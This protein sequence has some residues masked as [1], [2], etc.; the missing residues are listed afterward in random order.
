MKDE[1]TAPLVSVI[2]P[3][4]Q[5]APFIRTCL[6]SIL[7]Q[8]IAFPIEVLIG[9]D[10]STDGTR[11]ICQEIANAHPDR[12]RLFLNDRDNLIYLDGHPTGRR[13]VLDLYGRCRGRYI[14]LCEGD[15]LWSDPEKLAVQVEILERDRSCS[16]VFHATAVI[17]Q[18]GHPTGK[19]FRDHVPEKLTIHEAIAQRAPFHTSSLVFRNLPFLRK[20]PSWAE[21]VGSFDLVVFTLCAANGPLIGLQRN[22]SAYRKHEG[23]IT[24]SALHQGA[25]FD[26]HRI[27][28]WLHLDD[29]FHGR[30]AKEMGAAMEEH[31]RR[32]IGLCGRSERLRYLW[33]MTRQAPL[34]VLSH[35][36]RFA[37][38]WALALRA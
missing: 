21:K 13:N 10:G 15:D 38:W 20:P 32:L 35:P 27:L 3:T 18:D 37:R 24:R 16:G 31:F 28:V 34:Y 23:G 4:Y 5:H 12:I 26:H 17:D 14:A 33:Q 19:D 6:M 29:Y 11:A 2:E 25:S 9:E 1:G 30:W 7:E 36:K 8:R 22:M